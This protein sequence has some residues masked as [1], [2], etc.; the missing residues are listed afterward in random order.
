MAK[1]VERAYQIVRR[2]ILDGRLAPGER[3]KEEDLAQEIGVSRTPIREAL[4]RLD[5]EGLLSFV[6]NQGAR[7]A[8]WADQDIEEIFSLRALLESHA[9]GLAAQRMTPDALDRLRDLATRMEQLVASG[10]GSPSDALTEA[11]SDFHHLIQ[12]VAGNRRLAAMINN[13]MEMP[14]IVNTFRRYRP[15]DLRRSASHHIEMVAAFEN[16][17]ADWAASV[18]RS[19]VRAAYATY[20]ARDPGAIK[21]AE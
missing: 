21:A 14:V 12:E 7:V 15:A 6:P 8:D 2:G 4:R 9:A 5:L 1:A 10:D 19:H 18:M 20:A 13:L 3:L 17:D 16:R 11:N